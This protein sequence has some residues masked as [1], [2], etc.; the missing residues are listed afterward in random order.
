MAI[1]AATPMK[2]PSMVSAERIMLRRIA[3]T[4]AAMIISPKLQKALGRG[5]A[6]GAARCRRRNG[7]GALADVASPAGFGFR[8]SEMTSP[9]RMVSTRSA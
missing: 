6:P 7:T 3:C 1:S 8:L 9:S 4:A 2:T 5:A